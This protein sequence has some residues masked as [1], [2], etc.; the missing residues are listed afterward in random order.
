[1]KNEK[2]ETYSD[3][4]FDVLE[5]GL[6]LVKEPGTVSDYVKK[7]IKKKGNKKPAGRKSKPTPQ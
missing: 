3:E 4:D 1:M 2:T 6:G 5:E 7:S